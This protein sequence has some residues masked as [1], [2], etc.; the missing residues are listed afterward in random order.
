MTIHQ[1]R[2]CGEEQGASAT[3]HLVNRRISLPLGGGCSL[4]C[5]GR[6]RSRLAFFLVGDCFFARCWGVRFS[7]DCNCAA[8]VQR[9]GCV[10]LS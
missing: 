5:L 7:Y 4:S 2:T 3:T 10:E 9:R 8:V 6:G 1:Q